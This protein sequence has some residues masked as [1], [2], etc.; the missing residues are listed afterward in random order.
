VEPLPG[1]GLPMLITGAQQ[2]LAAGLKATGS[3]FSF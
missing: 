1:P 2:A 3:L